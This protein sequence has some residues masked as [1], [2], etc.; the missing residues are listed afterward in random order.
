MNV[1]MSQNSGNPPE[2]RKYIRA[3]FQE[4]VTVHQVAESK[5]GNVFEVQGNPITVKAQDVSEGGIR[6]EIGDVNSPSKIFKLNFKL[7]K[8]GSVDVYSKL[9]WK[10]DG[11]C[12][13]QFIVLD[14]ESRKL[15]KGYIGK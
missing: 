2:R 3:K 7:P 11:H 13:L 15:I 5:S 4:T 8:I 14:D 6:L 12:G 1:F 9:A 10:N